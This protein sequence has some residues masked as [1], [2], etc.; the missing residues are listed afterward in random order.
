MHHVGQTE[1]EGDAKRPFD[2]LLDSVHYGPLVRAVIKPLDLPSD[3]GMFS[4]PVV[5]FNP[6]ADDEMK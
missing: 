2:L 1:I 3:D 6:V 4:L 5:T